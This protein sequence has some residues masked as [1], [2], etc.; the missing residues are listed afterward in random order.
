SCGQVLRG[1]GQAEQVGEWSTRFRHE[2]L[3]MRLRGKPM[4]PGE[5]HPRTIALS[6]G[7]ALELGCCRW[8]VA[9]LAEQ[10][11][12]GKRRRVAAVDARQSV[13]GGEP[14]ICLCVGRVTRRVI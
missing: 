10:D 4:V 8:V 1:L 12:T 11:T 13:D 5:K 2:L 3:K 14:M 6:F 9:E 7:I